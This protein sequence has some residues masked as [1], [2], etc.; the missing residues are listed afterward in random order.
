METQTNSTNAQADTIIVTPTWRER[1]TT[2]AT[3]VKFSART[4]LVV[5]GCVL[6]GGVCWLYTQRDRSAA[7]Q[8]GVAK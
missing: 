6:V 2:T 4:L 8:M 1:I 7:P 3:S 5:G